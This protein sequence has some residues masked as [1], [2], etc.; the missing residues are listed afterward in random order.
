L[1]ESR[2]R[3]RLI[4]DRVSLLSFQP[5]SIRH[6]DLGLQAFLPPAHGLRMVKVQMRALAI[7]ERLDHRGPPVAW[8]TKARDRVLAISRVVV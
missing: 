3:L 2:R 7:P 8:L 5:A 1:P 6:E 4:L